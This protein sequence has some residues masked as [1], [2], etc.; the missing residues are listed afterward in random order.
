ME[1]FYNSNNIVPGF[2]VNCSPYRN[3]EVDKLFDEQR[4]Q[5]DP[6]ARKAAYDKIQAIIW[7]DIPV[8]LICAYNLPGAVRST[9]ATGVYNCDSSN[10]DD[11]AAAKPDKA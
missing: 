8:F 9:A 3:P 1:R 7:A 4:M 11:Y 5:T 6:A 10:R 2:F